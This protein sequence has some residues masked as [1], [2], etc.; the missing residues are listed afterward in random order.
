VPQS[1]SCKKRL[2]I[3]ARQN[4]TNRS[5]RSAIRTK[6]KTIRSAEEK[7]VIAAEVPLLFSMLDKA[8][9]RR[10]AGFTKNRAG[11]YKSK[12]QKILN[13]KLAA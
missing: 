10:Q 12:I 5:V 13:A 3:T 1:K 7:E 11:N 8:A 9:R 2:K 4:R 6:I